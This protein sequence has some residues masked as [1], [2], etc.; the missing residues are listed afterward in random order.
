M[1]KHSSKK[2]EVR[3]TR[4]TLMFFY[5][6]LLSL[7]LWAENFAYYR[8]DYIFRGMLPWFL[9]IA[10][11][12]SIALLIF[13]VQ[14]RKKQKEAETPQLFSPAFMVVL[15]APLPAIF[16]FPWL[17]TFGKG[18][19]LFKLSV[20]LVF[21]G[22]VAYFIGYLLYHWI[23][24]AAA[25]LC[26]SIAANGLALTYFYRMYLSPS[27]YILNAAEFGYLPDWAAMLILCGI[28]GILLLIALYINRAKAFALAKPILVAPAGFTSLILLFTTV[29]DPWLS[30]SWIRIL[31]FGGIGLMI[32]W[33][34]I[35]CIFFSIKKK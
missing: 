22:V 26:G 5:T 30:G 17:S 29:A 31:L 16:L 18:L 25:L 8:F 7:L 10:S 35:Q 15:A 32:C 12:L 23:R 28:L 21:L 3:S 13:L 6:L 20:L 14:R 1:A 2:A 27:R 19:Q 4:I 34:I 11:I 24:P 9:P 33:L